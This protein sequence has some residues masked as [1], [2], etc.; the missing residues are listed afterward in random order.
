MELLFVL[1][2]WG[3]FCYGVYKFSDSKGRNNTLWTLVA[4]LFSPLVA[5]I[6]LLFMP[7][8]IEKQAEEAKR[9]KELMND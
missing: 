2:F 4:V 9:L 7:K 3:L 5:F 1:V 6:I 8:T